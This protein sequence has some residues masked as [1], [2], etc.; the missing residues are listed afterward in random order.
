MNNRQKFINFINV[1]FKPYKEQFKLLK[2]TQSCETHNKGEFTLLLHQ[3][4]VRD[5]L[6]IYSPY[7]GLLLFHGLGSGKTCTSIAIA[8]GLK[9][10][11]N[12]IIMTPASLRRNYIDELKFCGDPIFKKKQYWEFIK[13]DSEQMVQELNAILSINSDYISKNKGAWLVNVKKESNF[14]TLTPED[15]YSLDSQINEMI[16]TKY[17]FMNYNGMRDSHLKA[18][19]LDFTIN[20]FD[21]KT[22]IIAADTIAAV[23]KRIIG[24]AETPE[25]AAKD[26]MLMSGRKSSVHT[27]LCII[28]GEQRSVKL[29]T[30]R[31]K[32]KKLTSQAKDLPI[33]MKA[34]EPL[35]NCAGLF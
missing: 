21:N 1:L 3:K 17:Q 11:Q 14:D 35:S 19:T 7:R 24:K 9:T 8:E 23:G 18:L 12:I 25:Q 20:P 29:I 16:R 26:V 10:S 27:G 28:S 2:A 4:L 5:Y 22:I 34:Q 15:K 6:N 13:A 30:S 32:M 33:K 31:V